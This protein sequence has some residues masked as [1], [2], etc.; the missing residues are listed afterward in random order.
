MWE[1]YC[2]NDLVKGDELIVLLE[3][4]KNSTIAPAFGKIAE[5][6]IPLWEQLPEGEEKD[7]VLSLV[8]D[9]QTTNSKR[10]LELALQQVKKYEGSE[11]YKEALRIVGLRDG[12]SFAHCLGRFALLMHLCEGNF[13][14]HQGGWGLERLWESPFFSKKSLWSLREY[15]LQ[16]TFPLRQLSV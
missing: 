15:L 16:K 7:K 6:V 1:E 3:K 10:L 11:N 2:F 5:S 4:I 8:F 12:I 9:V 14:F 13:V